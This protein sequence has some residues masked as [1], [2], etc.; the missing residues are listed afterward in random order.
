MNKIKYIFVILIY[1][2]SFQVNSYSL[3]GEE[4]I[5]KTAAKLNSIST[6]EGIISLSY[7][8][9]M[10]YTGVFKFLAP[11]YFHIK[12]TNPAG[13]TIVSNGKKL[14]IYDE[15]NNVCGVQDLEPEKYSG[16]LASLT[17]GYFAI[18]NESENKTIIKLKSNEKVFK[19]ISLLVNKSYM[20]KK[21][22]F[23]KEDGEGFSAILSNVKTGHKIHHRHFNFDVPA[24]AQLIKNPLNIR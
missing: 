17:K 12:F 4:A 21:I 6:M 23:Q 15:T 1:I 20:L 18:V 22:S 3:T 19:E 16:G 8:S 7:S 10:V 11:G 9:G 14:W 5:N 2:L 13:K 24:N